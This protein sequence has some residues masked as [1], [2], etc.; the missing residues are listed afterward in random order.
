MANTSIWAS[1]TLRRSYWTDYKLFINNIAIL[2][3]VAQ[4]HLRMLDCALSSAMH[5]AN[6]MPTKKP[7][8]GSLITQQS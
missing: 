5:A 3:D 4:F 7:S 1:Y 2:F 6:N 8:S